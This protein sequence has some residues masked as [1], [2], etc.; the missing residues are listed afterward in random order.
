MRKGDQGGTSTSPPDSCRAR[1]PSEGDNVRAASTSPADAP[2]LVPKVMLDSG[3]GRLD[4]GTGSLRGLRGVRGLRGLAEFC[5]VGSRRARRLSY[6][7]FL[8]QCVQ[9]SMYA[10]QWNRI[11]GQLLPLPSALLS[12]GQYAYSYCN[13]QP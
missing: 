7:V 10:C 1:V 4:R 12:A 8:G 2:G 6:F 13:K 3:T 9:Q 5:G 11:L